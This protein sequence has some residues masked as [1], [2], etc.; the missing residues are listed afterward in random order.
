MK[1]WWT[2]A[3]ALEALDNE[4]SNS[5]QS[6]DDW[7]SEDSLSGGSQPL[8]LNH[9]A[10]RTLDEAAAEKVKQAS[11]EIAAKIRRRRRA[12]MPPKVH[13]AR[14][15]SPRYNESVSTISS[16]DSWSESDISVEPF[17]DLSSP[18]IERVSTGEDVERVQ[19]KITSKRPSSL[20][21]IYY[22]SRRS[23]LTHR[24]CTRPRT[25]PSGS[26]A[27]A[28]AKPSQPF[29]ARPIPASTLIPQYDKMVA[30]AEAKRKL[31]KA[32][33]RDRMQNI[34]MPFKGMEMRAAKQAARQKE[35]IREAARAFAAAKRAKARPS[36]R[37]S[38]A[39]AA[40][41]KEKQEM[42]SRR[43]KMLRAERARKL[44]ET[45]CA[46][47]SERTTASSKV[48]SSN[49]ETCSFQP[50]IN[51]HVPDFNRSFA[52]WKSKLDAARD[53]R[54]RE[55]TRPDVGNLSMFGEEAKERDAQRKA[56]LKAKLEAALPRRSKVVK[57]IN[58]TPPPRVTMTKSEELRLKQ[59][60]NRKKEQGE[61][62]LRKRRALLAAAE[63]KA[64]IERAVRARV[65]QVE[66]ERQAMPGYV[67]LEEAQRKAKEN[68]RRFKRQSKESF[69]PKSAR[70]E[71]SSRNLLIDRGRNASRK[72]QRRKEALVR[73]AS[74]IQTT[75]GRVDGLEENEREIV[76]LDTEPNE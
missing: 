13:E 65:R 15:R 8:D 53:A 69:S 70:A 54:R 23:G 75:V 33:R 29:K 52:R 40:K 22:S 66:R 59:A 25:S 39:E 46:P 20:K 76:D 6:F 64:S 26:T 7:T 48:K 50:K 55:C 74:V 72:A 41:R 42:A 44:L 49:E 28:E 61:M 37:I 30:R 56:K 3:S 10:F 67:S 34:A 19:P 4:W 27:P 68:A 16:L 21:G 18:D 17:E 45:A 31:R 62:E 47:V 63:R 32:E 9:C 51:P 5:L 43:R 2:E 14:L 73:A 24:E 35:R 38:S 36:L 1:E 12:R 11:A 58:A 57:S 60:M 71:G